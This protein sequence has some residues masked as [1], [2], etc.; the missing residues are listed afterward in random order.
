MVRRV[1]RLIAP[2]GPVAEDDFHRG[3]AF[4]RE[5]FEV[6][7]REDILARNG[8]FAGSDARRLE[9][10]HEALGD[11]DA[12]AIVAV[13][14]G[15]GAIPIIDKIDV[16]L[17]RR[18]SKPI[19]GFSDVTALHLL[20]AR[21][22]VP[23]LHSSMVGALGRSASIRRDWLHSVEAFLRERSPA[24]LGGLD[25]WCDGDATGPLLGGNLR[26]VTTLAGTT[27]A[28]NFDGAILL[29]EDVGERAYR[30]DRLLHTLRLHGVFAQVAGVVLG[31]FHECHGSESVSTE[32][33]L[34]AFF[35]DSPFPVMAGLP[36]GHG[37]R[38][39]SVPFGRTACMEAGVL[40]FDR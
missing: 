32:S 21:E 22:G 9:E 24:A 6:R 12:D 20:W 25:V 27:L 15:H 30:I 23:S 4:L 16:G 10:L 34:R 11:V 38:N 3:V 18:A 31:D 37:A 7:F 29:L 1:L 14:G 40:R 19:L 26:V 33:V 35:S 39:V 36:V 8:L 2:S 13:R 5:H 28:P 17:V